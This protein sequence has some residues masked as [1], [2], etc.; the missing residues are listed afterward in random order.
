M[1][2][3]VK[4]YYNLTQKIKLIAIHLFFNIYPQVQL[5]WPQMWN[6]SKLQFIYIF[7]NKSRQ[8]KF[9]L[10]ISTSNIMLN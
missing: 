7:F 3:A 10:E 4:P 6:I 8:P 5:F 1:L 9:E 2:Y